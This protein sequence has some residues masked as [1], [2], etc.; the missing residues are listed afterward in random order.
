MQICSVLLRTYEDL[1]KT[2]S[3]GNLFC[4]AHEAKS[5][6]RKFELMAPL[7]WQKEQS[8]RSRRK[9]SYVRRHVPALRAIILFDRGEGKLC[10]VPHLWFNSTQITT[11]Q[12]LQVV[13]AGHFKSFLKVSVLGYP[14]FLPACPYLV[15]LYVYGCAVTYLVQNVAR[16]SCDNI[17]IRYRTTLG[18]YRHLC[19]PLDFFTI[20]LLV[21][22]ALNY[23]VSTYLQKDT[24]QI[25]LD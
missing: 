8:I 15:R 9:T 10:Y 6:G 22:E 5:L 23:T 21:G 18:A 7:A 20:F 1:Y 19:E 24:R 2:V 11:R 12:L 13:K 3:L 25:S 17:N 4:D 16:G 14:G